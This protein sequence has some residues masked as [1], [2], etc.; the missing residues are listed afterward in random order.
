MVV[1]LDFSGGVVEDSYSQFCELTFDS[2]DFVRGCGGAV[3]FDYCYRAM[4][5]ETIYNPEEVVFVVEC[6]L[7]FPG[8]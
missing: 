1:V 7:K 5:S 6:C 2:N 4:T 3:A 8:A